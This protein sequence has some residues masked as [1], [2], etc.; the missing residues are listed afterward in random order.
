MHILSPET[1]DAIRQFDT[2]MIA[3]AIEK[4]DRRLRNEG[5]TRPGLRCVTGGFSRL[6]GYAATCRIRSSDPPISGDS[7]RDRTNWWDA[8]GRL[9]APRVAVV[10]DLE[11]ASGGTVVGE[12]HAAILKAFHCGGLVT[13]GSVRDLP[14]VKRLDFP[15]FAGSVGVSHAYTHLVDYGNPVEIFGLKILPGD[16]LYTDCHGAVSIPLDIAAAIPEVAAG[17]RLKEQRIVTLCQEPDF[18]PEMLLEVIG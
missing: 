8:I 16:L 3:N 10:Q 13:N 17:I 6:L 2:C 5:F 7:Y 12:V 1:L 11:P 9:P 15:M 14:G 4:L 18:S